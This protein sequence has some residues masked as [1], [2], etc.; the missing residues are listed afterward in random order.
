M[1]SPRLRRALANTGIELEDLQVRR[2]ARPHGLR[3]PIIASCY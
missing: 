3:A 1:T 2:A